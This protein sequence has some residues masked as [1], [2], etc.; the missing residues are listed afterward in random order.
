MTWISIDRAGGGVRQS[1]HHLR[2]GRTYLPP[3]GA[4]GVRHL[5]LAGGPVRAGGAGIP[6]FY[7]RTGVGTPI[8]DG[9]PHADFDEVTHIQE[10]AIVADV[11][12]VHAHTADRE[13]NLVFRRTS[14]NFNPLV[15]TCG[16]V[17]V[18]ETEVLL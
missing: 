5:W 3:H 12:L 17:T 9:K 1:G 10:R 13:G 8:A 7:T 11:A 14:R 2:I 18:A 15:A 6:A 16:M 4:V